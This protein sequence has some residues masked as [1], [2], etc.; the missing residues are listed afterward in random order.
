LVDKSGYILIYK[1]DHPQARGRGYVREHRLVVE[2]AIGRYLKT[3][4]VVD[5]IDGSKD[6]NQLSNLRVFQTNADHLRVTLKGK[7]PKWTED[8]I[9]R[10]REGVQR[11]SDKSH[12]RKAAD[13]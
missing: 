12:L 13:G 10:I 8:G 6:N 1:P 5:H 4:E 9:R 2:A 11:Q 7:C 3:S